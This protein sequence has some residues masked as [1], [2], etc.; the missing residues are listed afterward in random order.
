VRFGRLLRVPVHELQRLAGVRLGLTPSSHRDAEA[1]DVG[2]PT[3]T[4]VEQRPRK[5]RR[6]GDAQPRS[7]PASPGDDERPPLDLRFAG[8][9]LAPSVPHPARAELSA[10]EATPC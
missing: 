10:R 6:A 5:P 7:S 4:D 9:A 8:D 1:N 3:E 2:R